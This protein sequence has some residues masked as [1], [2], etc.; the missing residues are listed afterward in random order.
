MPK[1]PNYTVTNW[2]M[3]KCSMY[4]KK[5]EKFTIIFNFYDSQPSVLN[6]LDADIPVRTN[7][8]HHSCLISLI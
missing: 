7:T 1:P 6:P 4:K 3:P 8:S 2:L 5:K